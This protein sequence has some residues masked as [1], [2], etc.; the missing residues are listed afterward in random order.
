[1]KDLKNKQ[2]SI[3]RSGRRVA[4]TPNLMPITIPVGPGEFFDRLTILE[5]K[6]QRISD[7]VALST[8]IQQLSRFNDIREKRL[9]H[10]THCREEL[11]KR[12]AALRVANI[13]LWEAEDRIRNCNRANDFGVT[14][15]ELAKVI[16]HQN[17]NRSLIKA[18]I[19]ALFSSS[20]SDPKYYQPSD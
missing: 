3:T 16:C 12:L 2:M 8:V 18:E 15:V 17:D 13:T 5:I 10:R 7:P 6:Q 11:S 20:V 1:M 19:D 9:T 4:S 14:F